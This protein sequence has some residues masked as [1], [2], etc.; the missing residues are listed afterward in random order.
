MEKKEAEE[1]GE[2][3]PNCGKPMVIKSGKYGKFEACSGYHE[4]KYIKK[5]RGI[6]IIPLHEELNLINSN[7]IYQH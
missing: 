7:Y 4:C 3:C 6:K 1:T 5:K 2:T